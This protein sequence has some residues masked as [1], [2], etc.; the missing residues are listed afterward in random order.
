MIDS[1]ATPST[2]VHSE[3]EV[4]VHDDTTSADDPAHEDGSGD[5][6][7]D[8]GETSAADNQP[9]VVRRSNRGLKP[10]TGMIIVSMYYL[11]I[12]ES[13]KAMMKLWR[14]NTRMC[15]LVPWMRKWIL[16]RRITHSS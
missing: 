4:E 3:V 9:T 16:L 15:G 8:H 13:L 11:L 2:S 5:H 12:G 1:E 6:G 7:E 14:M 10:W